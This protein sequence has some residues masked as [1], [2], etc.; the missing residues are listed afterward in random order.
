MYI[1]FQQNRVSSIVKTV[2]TNI[3]ANNRRLHKF[4]TT[5]SN[6]K[7]NDFLDLHHRETYL[8]INFLQNRVSRSVKT[9]HTNLFTKNAIA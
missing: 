2:H 9:V 5:N 4:A 1:I 3:F 6:F 8:Y 7:K